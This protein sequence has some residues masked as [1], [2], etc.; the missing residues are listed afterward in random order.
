MQEFAQYGKTLPEVED[1]C[2][3]T[4]SGVS[5]IVNDIK[6]VLGNA[7]LLKNEMIDIDTFLA[8]KNINNAIQEKTML[9]LGAARK[10]WGAVIVS[11]VI[12]Q[13]AGAVVA[14]LKQR[15]L[16]LVILSGDN[17]AAVKQCAYTLGIEEFYGKLTPQDKLEK[18]KG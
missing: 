10:V 17:P 7:D 2:S 5:G 1:F 8:N 4:G 13:D 15:N 18:V 12:R 6:F 9:F 14:E 11:D 16:D 3:M